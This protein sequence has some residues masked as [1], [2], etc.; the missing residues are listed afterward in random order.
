M[1]SFAEIKLFEDILWF[2]GSRRLTWLN[3]WVY[4]WRKFHVLLCFTTAIL[5]A[6]LYPLVFP[7]VFILILPVCFLL[8]IRRSCLAA[9]L[10][11]SCKGG[12]L[13]CLDLSSI[14]QNG[15]VTSSGAVATV[16]PVF[17]FFLYYQN[18]F[19]LLFWMKYVTVILKRLFIFSLGLWHLLHLIFK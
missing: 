7:P 8:C 16:S 11:L 14:L 15:P 12:V 2:W 17:F 9:V 18:L 4:C 3:W 19:S 10:L 13:I 1:L 6:S 5:I